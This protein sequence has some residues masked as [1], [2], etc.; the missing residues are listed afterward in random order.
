MAFHSFTKVA[1]AVPMA[2]SALTLGNPATVRAQHAPFRTGVDMVALTVTVTDGAGKHITG[3]TGNDFTVFEDGA[4]QPLSFFAS[5]KVPVDVAL[6]IDASASMRPDLPLVQKAACGLIRTLRAFDRGAVVEVKTAIRIPQPLT[7]DHAQ[8]EATIRGLTASGTTALYDGLYMM[9]KEFERAQ[10][11]NPEVRR[12]VLILLSDGL[13]TTSHLPFDEV[14][15]LVRRLGVN[16]YVIA[17][18]GEAARVPRSEQHETLLQADY[19]LRAVAREA[20]GRAFFPT[21]AAE[22]PTIYGAIA[23]ELA[24]QYELGY[25]PVK[26]G[27][28]GTFRRVFVRL[29]PTTNANARTRSGYYAER[30]GN[31]SALATPTSSEPQ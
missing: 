4:Q 3:L 17:L 13:D 28:D 7:F 19:S 27:G 11:G 31:R 14:M 5:E 22:L 6:V 21:T 8:V 2:L 1:L 23:Q 18:R 24:S 25:V 12:Q 16:I 29:A 9:L 26:P 20:G 10:R 30:S 15:E